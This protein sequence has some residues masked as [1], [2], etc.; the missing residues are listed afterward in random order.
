MSTRIRST[1][2]NSIGFTLIELLVVIGMM[3]ALALIAIPAFSAW[4]PEYR[5]KQAA[6]ELYSN[7]QRAKMGAV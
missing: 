7:I 2:N 4:M 5:L 6:R 3:A 1:K